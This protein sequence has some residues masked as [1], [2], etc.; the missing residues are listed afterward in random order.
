MEEK[1]YLLTAKE[2]RKILGNISDTTLWRLTKKGQIPEAIKLGKKRYYRKSW[3][4]Q[5]VT[6]GSCSNECANLEA[7]A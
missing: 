2:F 1:D 5:I 4:D 7:S 3:A 6:S